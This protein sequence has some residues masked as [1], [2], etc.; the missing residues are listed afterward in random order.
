MANITKLLRLPYFSLVLPYAKVNGP[1]NA[2]NYGKRNTQ[3]F[4]LS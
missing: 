4:R 1:T 2:Y 3:L